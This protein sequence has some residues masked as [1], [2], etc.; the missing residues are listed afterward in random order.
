MVNLDA[1][2]ALRWAYLGEAC[3]SGDPT[4]LAMGVVDE[5]GDDTVL[6]WQLAHRLADQSRPG[7]ARSLR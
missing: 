6:W 4:K 7:I 2:A 1:A 3:G 5:R